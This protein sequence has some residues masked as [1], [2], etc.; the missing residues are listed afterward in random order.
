[1]KTE[2]ILKTEE[3]AKRLVTLCRKNEWETAQKELYADEAVSI[4]PE[5]TEAFAKETKG[6]P[7]I[8]E[9]GHQFS[10]MVEKTYSIK[11]SEPLVAGDSFACVMSTDMKMKGRDRMTMTELCVYE[12]KDGK[13]CSEQFHM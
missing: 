3:I 1:M 7:A 5:E 12:V 9:K 4:E 13:I 2:E 11:V 6:L 10:K 8:I